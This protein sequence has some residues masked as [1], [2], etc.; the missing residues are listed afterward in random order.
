MKFEDIFKEKGLYKA[1]SF[2]KGCC[3]EVGKDDCLYLLEYDNKDDLT[4][5]RT[6][7]ICYKAMFEKDY[8]KVF[9]RQSLFQ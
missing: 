2:A 5:K 9:T 7:A 8:M 3:Y 4:P 6:N 1:E